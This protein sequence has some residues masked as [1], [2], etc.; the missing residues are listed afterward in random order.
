LEVFFQFQF[1]LK[2]KRTTH[3][4]KKSLNKTTG[5]LLIGEELKSWVDISI[6]HQCTLIFDEFYSQYLYDTEQLSVSATEFVR[7]V[8][9]DPVIIFDGLTKN[10]RYPGFRVAWTIGPKSMI[11]AVG[12]AGSFIDGGCSRVMQIVIFLRA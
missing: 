8:N 2:Q 6:E 9:K 5:T 10:W 7:D 3:L 1:L 11:E 4:A 12:S